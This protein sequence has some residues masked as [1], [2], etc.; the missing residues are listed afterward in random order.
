MDDGSC[1]VCAETLEW[2]AYGP[3]GHRDVCALCIARLRFVCDDRRCCIC[4]SLSP[5]IFVTRALGSLTRVI[6]D[7]SILPA[8]AKD[9]KVGSYWYH[10]DTQAYFDDFDE[11]KIIKAMCRLSCSVCDKLEAEGKRT[12]KRRGKIKS[13]EQL[14]NHLSHQH[15]LCFCSLC[16]EYKKVFVSEQKLYSRVQLRQH[17]RYGDSEVDGSENERCGFSG[18]PLC[19]FCHRSFYGDNEIH[20]HMST[21]HYTCHICQRLDSTE[22]DYYKDY[23]DLENHFG[24]AHF[25]CEEDTCLEKKFIVFSTEA[26]MKRHIASEH[27]GKMSRSYKTALQLRECF[28]HPEREEGLRVTEH[29]SFVETSNIQLSSTS[30]ANEERTNSNS[31]HGAISAGATATT[32]PSSGQLQGATLDFRSV[33]LS[34]SEYPALPGSSKRRRRKSKKKSE[35]TGTNHPPANSS[36]QFQSSDAGHLSQSSPI[37]SREIEPLAVGHFPSSSS[38]N[39]YGNPSASA[40]SWTDSIEDVGPSSSVPNL[41][42]MGAKHPSA[43]DKSK[44]IGDDIKAAN[45]S[46]VERI[47]ASLEYDKDKYAAFKIISKEYRDCEIDAGEYF[48]YVHQFGLAHLIGDLA[49]L[50][51]DPRKQKE[52]MEIHV[53]SLGDNINGNGMRESGKSKTTAG[54]HSKKGKEKCGDFGRTIKGET[55]SDDSIANSLKKLNLNAQF[56]EEDPP[57]SKIVNPVHRKSQTSAEL[58]EDV[59]HV[60]GGSSN[61]SP[62]TA[63]T[64]VGRKKTKKKSKFLKTRL[65]E[66]SLSEVP[67]INCSSHLASDL[68]VVRS[69]QDSILASVRGVWRND[70]GRRLVTMSQALPSNR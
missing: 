16:L 60:N 62:E 64:T 24:E 32:V 12:T 36:S 14:K 66:S 58:S 25:L 46:L 44:L 33:L 9:G 26:D 30:S 27:G 34:G 10:E 11:F 18:H 39:S 63:V 15:E 51:P 38:I 31:L 13:V 7:F 61:S 2:V 37:I 23:N 1:A 29:V 57:L 5:S 47:R 55:L 35:E 3:C 22:Y 6:N 45:K 42:D 41:I 40:N 68:L 28:H 69:N 20:F 56:Q 54:K 8:D 4:Q 17:I 67:D 59:V 52:L 43:S 48:A 49:R 50:C 65:G 70:G 21:E 53:I 19:D